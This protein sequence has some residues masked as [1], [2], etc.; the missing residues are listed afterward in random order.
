MEEKKNNALEKAQNIAGEGVNP[1]PEQTVGE[2]MN[3]QLFNVQ[4]FNENN[5]QPQNSNEQV[6][7]DARARIKQE[8]MREKELAKAERERIQAERRIELAKIRAH[9]RHER[10]KIKAAAMREK[11]KRRLEQKEKRLALKAQ[12]EAK[13][14]ALKNE[15]KVERQRRLSLEKQA[16][17]DLKRENRE[18]KMR[19]R[20]E[21]RKQNK[22]VGGWLAAVIS[23]GIATLVLASVLT[24][25]F[26]MPTVSDNMLEANYSKSFYDTVKQVDNIDVNL[27]KVLAT[28]DGGAIQRYLVDTAINSELAE[29]DL[30][31]L[32]LQDES[33]FYTTK[34]INQIGDYAKYLNNKL[35]SGENLTQSDLKT[36]TQLYTANKAL[37][38]ALGQMRE[39]MGADYA[40][41]SMLDGGKG[42]IVISNFNELQNLSVDYPEL[43]YDGPF[44]DGQNE[45]EIKG[46][47][48]AEIDEMRAKEIFGKIFSKHNV[49]KVI[50]SGQADGLIK[51]FN[52]QGQIDGDVLYAQISKQGGKLL[53][54][55]FSGSCDSVNID[56]DTAVE[57]ALDFLKSLEIDNMK[58]VWINLANNVY[59]INMAYE[60]G[61]VIVYSDLIKV[62]VCA[63][64]G[65]VIGLEATSYYTNHTDRVIESATL[66]EKTAKAKVSSNI[67]VQTSRLAVVPIGTKSEKLCYEFSGEYDG[68]TYYVYI[69]AM[70]GAQLEMFKVIKST[71][72]TLLI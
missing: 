60:Q 25:T 47:S 2:N 38:D 16:R 26:L 44:S 65:M 7:I 59:T 39:K 6:S 32:P 35:I 13:K 4:N 49:E 63:E 46:L 8:Q 52:V 37:K 72:G 53:M 58:P 10:Q 57:V 20:S 68:S 56:D 50:S 27:S 40:F 15:S 12:N 29:N 41:S 17:L 55:A 42:D 71:E 18:R 70:T 66:S 43:I 33:K 67:D 1:M 51:C 54:F 3:A 28:S 14:Q 30:Q 22:G 61:G 19:E 69:D 9:K 24:F 31:Q 62:R 23:L 64:T 11:Q 48:G 21:R 45:R 34:L 5:S 36:L